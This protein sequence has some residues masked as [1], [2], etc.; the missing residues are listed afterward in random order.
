MIRED[1]VPHVASVNVGLPRPAPWAGLGATG[2]D[3]APAAG[4]VPV[5]SS[6]L[7]GDGVFDTVNHGGPDRAVSAYAREDLDHWAAQLG[8]SIGD[9]Q[10]SENLTTVGIDQGQCLLGERWRIGDVVLEVASVRTPCND[11]KTWMQRTGYDPSAWVKRFTREG[12]PGVYLR[13]LQEG[14]LRA[15]D[16]V[17]VVERPDHGITVATLFR[18]LTVEPALLPSLLAVDG[19]AGHLQE[20][21][22]AYMRPRARR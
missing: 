5:T 16:T 3:K 10:F 9:G 2:M 8:R 6:G 15:G 22:D 7:R 4:A 11:F 21:I 20:R 12:R 14:L 19:L 18:A 13:V 1:V 17:A